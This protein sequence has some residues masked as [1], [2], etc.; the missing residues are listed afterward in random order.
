VVSRGQ[1][2]EIGGSFRIPDIM[3]RS[4]AILREVGA[5]NRTHLRDY[6]TAINENTAALMR[7]HT[8]NFRILGFTCEA[9]LV[10]M[11]ALGRERGLPVIEDLGS[12]ALLDMSGAGL[13]G[14]PTVAGA[15]A[16]GADIVTF[17]GDKALG[18]PQAGIIVGRADLVARLRY[19]PLLRAL[20]PGKLT[21]GALEATLRQ[22]LDP[23]KARREVPALAMIM[24]SPQDLKAKARRLAAR[25]R[26]RLA[27]VLRA[28]LL[29]GV[30]RVGGGAFPEQ[31]LPT[32][33]V[34]LSAL[35]P[36][37]GPDKLR[38]ALLRADPPLV[39][40]V[41]RDRFCL[42]PRTLADDELILA[43]RVLEQAL[44]K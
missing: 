20:R 11:A 24:I 27:G 42:D 3:A 26:K 17:S 15:V 22:Y 41:E 12:G 7:V 38:R 29:P 2:V 13:V 9:S 40:R 37:L 5:T 4:G 28:E 23:E 33:L 21:L 34:A 6:A 10:E 31:D 44:A 16:D 36:D 1:L 18:G 32:T 43:A 14:E 8:S 19:N 35:D 30:S 39:G 25:I